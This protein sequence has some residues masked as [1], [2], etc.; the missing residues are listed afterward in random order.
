MKIMVRMATR[1]RRKERFIDGLF[2][3]PKKPNVVIKIHSIPEW[4]SDAKCSKCGKPAHFLVENMEFLCRECLDEKLG[5]AELETRKVL[6]SPSMEKAVS[7]SIY[8]WSPINKE[9]WYRIKGSNIK[10]DSNQVIPNEEIQKRFYQIIEE[11]LK[12]NPQEFEA[13]YNKSEKEL[14]VKI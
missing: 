4:A 6:S 5:K 2:F 12:G 3:E 14:T 1:T 10:C 9:T 13:E 8:E 7:S 11:I